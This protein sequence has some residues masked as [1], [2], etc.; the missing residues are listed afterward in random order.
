MFST[1]ELLDFDLDAGLAEVSK[2]GNVARH[3]QDFW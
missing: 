2:V 3:P 1:A